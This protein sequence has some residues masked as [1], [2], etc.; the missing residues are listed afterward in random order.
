MLVLK[1]HIGLPLF[2]DEN[3]ISPPL[4]S[5]S[6]S[7]YSSSPASSSTTITSSFSSFLFDLTKK[8]QQQH[9]PSSC[10]IANRLRDW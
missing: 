4:S 10:F 6:S 5:T 1:G 9:A 8:T 2:L 3:S 7:S